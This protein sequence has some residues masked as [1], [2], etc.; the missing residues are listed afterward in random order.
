M[1]QDVCITYACNPLASNPNNQEHIYR[2]EDQ[3]YLEHNHTVQ[4]QCD[5][6]LLKRL[7]HMHS[8]DS[9]NMTESSKIL[10]K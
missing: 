7:Q 3:Q 9:R 6:H 1:V 5:I 8:Y 2:N 10:R 4:S